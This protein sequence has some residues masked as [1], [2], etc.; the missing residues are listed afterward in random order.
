MEPAPGAKKPRVYFHNPNQPEQPA[1]GVYRWLCTRDAKSFTLYVGNAGGR[2][3]NGVRLPSTL[4]RGIQEL[5]RSCGV[6]SD[7]GQSLDT[8]FVV[9]TAIQYFKEKGFDCRWE[10]VSGDPDAERELC[11]QYQPMLQNG[12]AKLN[13]RLLGRKHGPWDNSR[14]AAAEYLVTTILNAQTLA[15]GDAK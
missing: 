3:T 2:G 5:Q 1:A 14:C 7:S 9:G 10:H 13:A 8:D 6:S 11:R 4:A 12:K 15:E